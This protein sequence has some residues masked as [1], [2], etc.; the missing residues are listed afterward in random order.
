MRVCVAGDRKTVAGE[1]NKGIFGELPLLL[2]RPTASER[3][4]VIMGEA[5]NVCVP[6]IPTTLLLRTT[7]GD[8]CWDACDVIN[9]AAEGCINGD[10]HG[11]LIRDHRFVPKAVV[12]FLNWF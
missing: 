5:L 7:A 3:V 9:G 2:G 12:L 11:E 4:A 6:D 8:R 1:H 10:V